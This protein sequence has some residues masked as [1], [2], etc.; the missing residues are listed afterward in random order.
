MYCFCIYFGLNNIPLVLKEL[1]PVA[2][3]GSPLIIRYKTKT[4]KERMLSVK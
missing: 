2:K 4:D 3:V 1:E